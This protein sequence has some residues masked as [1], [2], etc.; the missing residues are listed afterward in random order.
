MKSFETTEA[1]LNEVRMGINLVDGQEYKSTLAAISTVTAEI[2]CKTLGPYASTT[3][4]DDG[5]YT[6][7][8]KDGWAVCNRLR[9]GDA[10]QNTLFKFIRDISFRLNSKVGDGTT[11]AII[12]ANKFI[13]ELKHFM[14]M[15]KAMVNG[16][17]NNIA[18]SKYRVLRQADLIDFINEAKDEIIKELTST[19]RCKFIDVNDKEFNDIY[20]IAFVSSN[21]NE[22]IARIIQQIYQQTGNP[23]IHVTMNGS[24]KNTYAEIQKGYKIDAELMF[25]RNYINTSEKTCVINQATNVTIFNHNLTYAD[26]VNIIGELMKNA[27]AAGHDTVIIA[28]Y[29]DEILRSIIGSQIESL[30]NKG[31]TANILL[32]KAPMQTASQKNYITDLA[33]IL[34]TQIFDYS[35]VRM[36]SQM[37]REQKGENKDSDEYAG[38]LENSNYEKPEDI[39]NA[40]IGVAN[41]ITLSDKYIMVEDFDKTTRSYKM[42]ADEIKQAFE[43]AK[44]DVAKGGNNLDKNYLDAHLRYIKFIGDTGIIKVGGESDLTKQCLKDSIDDAVLACR[45]AF[46]NGYVRGLNIETIS[47]TYSKFVEALDNIDKTFTPIEGSFGTGH[48]VPADRVDEYAEMWIKAHI[49]MAICRTFVETSKEVMRNKYRDDGIMDSEYTWG[50][51]KYTMEEVI[52][53]CIDENLCFDIVTEK[54]ETAGE[55]LVNSVS[56]DVE[57]LSAMTSIL[58]LLMS[59]DQ[60]LSLNKLYDK[61]AGRM[62]V[63]QDKFDEAEAYGAGIASA[64]VKKGCMLFEETIQLDDE[65]YDDEDYDDD[66]DNF[67]DEVFNDIDNLVEDD[68]VIE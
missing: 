21:R 55:S 36:Y 31:A 26:H 65:D 37:I 61:R 19:D 32:V 35:R 27:A 4:I 24:E 8:T 3:T 12:A 68:D 23:N 45:S 40:C 44:N 42:A 62:Q 2:L 53:K 34:N 52:Q 48:Q 7:P 33:A 20:K 9:F 64:L 18:N 60:L 66:E 28:P 43:T 17:D 63:L 16:R 59:S 10:I 56:T 38:L 46:E 41:R 47:T 67:D 5:V 14:D 30:A 58:S 57:V 1:K 39:F 51:E 29:Y 6:Y 54:Y 13:A 25:L 15:Q 50:T 49:Y 11:T 22:E